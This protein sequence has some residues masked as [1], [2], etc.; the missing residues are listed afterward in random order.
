MRNLFFPSSLCRRAKQII[1]YAIRYFLLSP[2]QV[3]LAPRITTSNK[4]PEGSIDRRANFGAF[5]EVYGSNG[6][7]T[8]TLRSEFEFL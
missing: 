4:L 8:D 3:F 7:F 5:V 6:T 1:L 2:K